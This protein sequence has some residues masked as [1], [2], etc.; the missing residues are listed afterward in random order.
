MPGPLPRSPSYIRRITRLI[1]VPW[2]GVKGQPCPPAWR[3]ERGMSLIEVITTVA[4][5]GLIFTPIILITT[6]GTR[7]EHTANSQFSKQTE[8][9]KILRQIV[10]GEGSSSLLIHGSR[11]AREVNVTG[12]LAYRVENTVV[13][14]RLSGTTLYRKTCDATVP[15][16]TVNPMDATD[17]TVPA[18]G[19]TSVL[20]DVLQF[21]ASQD[22]GNPQWLTVKLENRSPGQGT[23]TSDAGVRMATEVIMHNLP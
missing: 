8:A 5:L 13:T 4:V 7:T 9:Y 19:W 2:A 23:R 16:C 20:T 22:P 15:G 21:T 11:E 1:R 18:N 14:Y 6:Q 10:D 12:G 3:D 17:P